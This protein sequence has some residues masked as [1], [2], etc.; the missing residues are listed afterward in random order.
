MKL[1]DKTATYF[2][3]M[4]LKVEE[5]DF[6]LIPIKITNINNYNYV[7][8]F[9]LIHQYSRN[10]DNLFIAAS[11]I[12]FEVQLK[13]DNDIFSRS[14]MKRPILKI[15]YENIDINENKEFSFTSNYFMDLTNIMKWTKVLF[16]IC[17][18]L[19]FLI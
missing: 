2:Y 12:I 19:V 6:Q 1:F 18:V 5:N 10:N 15:T 11:D 16:S 9:F 13:N 14:Y 7:K 17:F 4:Y 8:R 3:Q